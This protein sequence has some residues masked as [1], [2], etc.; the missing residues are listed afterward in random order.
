[1]KTKPNNEEVLGVKAPERAYDSDYHSPKCPFTGTLKVKNEVLRGKVVKKDI[2]HSATIEWSRSRQVPKYERFE[3]RRSRLRVHN[4]AAVDAQ[5]G[6][7]VIV[8]R[9]RPLS[10]TKNHVIIG[11]VGVTKPTPKTKEEINETS[12][13]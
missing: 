4:P 1:M 6:D 11:V 8:A 13:E 2:N 3:I 7:E 5:I 10:K 9:T 12:K